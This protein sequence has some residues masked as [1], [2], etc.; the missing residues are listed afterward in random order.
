MHSCKDKTWCKGG[1]RKAVTSNNNTDMIYS[2]GTVV[3]A[4]LTLQVN[5]EIMG[6][7]FKAPLNVFNGC[8]IYTILRQLFLYFLDAVWKDISLFKAKI[9]K[10]LRLIEMRFLHAFISCLCITFIH[11]PNTNEWNNALKSDILGHF[12]L[13]KNA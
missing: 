5:K 2:H 8:L 3:I 1:N 13:W 4:C 7:N 10:W 12:G 6:T 9:T 11:P